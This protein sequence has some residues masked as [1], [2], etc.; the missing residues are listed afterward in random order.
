MKRSEIMEME[1]GLKLDRLVNLV[2]FGRSMSMVVTSLKIPNYSTDISDAWEVVE[3]MFSMG[4]HY[5]LNYLVKLE[6]PNGIRHC[7]FAKLKEGFS[8]D[9]RMTVQNDYEHYHARCN[10]VTESICKAAL[11]AIL[12]VRGEL[13]E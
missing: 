11:I 13:E 8:G 7:C 1:A 9:I 5:T 6:Y 4:Y 12:S 3:K 10:A 2:V